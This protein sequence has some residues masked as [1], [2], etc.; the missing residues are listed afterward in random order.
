MG[1]E[2]LC[3]GT[4]W[5]GS[6]EHSLIARPSASSVLV[7]SI[8]SSM[9]LFDSAA[10]CPARS[11]SSPEKEGSTTPFLTRQAAYRSAHLAFVGLTFMAW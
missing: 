3:R 10:F 4:Y 5:F 8:T 11:Q 7:Y 6:S 1:D 9:G 2:G